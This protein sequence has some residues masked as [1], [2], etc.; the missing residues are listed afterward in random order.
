MLINIIKIFFKEQFL[1][2][3]NNPR[4][5]NMEILEKGGG[6]DY[7]TVDYTAEY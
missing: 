4:N 1:H 2:F 3:A 5:I 6:G 7:V